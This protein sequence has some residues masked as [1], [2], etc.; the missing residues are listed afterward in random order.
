MITPLMHVFVIFAT[1]PTILFG[2]ITL[3][4][5]ECVSPLFASSYVSTLRKLLSFGFRLFLANTTSWKIHCAFSGGKI[6]VGDKL[7]HDPMCLGM[8]F[9]NVAKPGGSDGDWDDKNVMLL[10]FNFC[11]LPEFPLLLV[12]VTVSACCYRWCIT[13]WKII[14]CTS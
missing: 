14:Y 5:T 12:V 7:W 10:D 6:Q 9:S 8:I 3:K 13:W 4:R 1:E 2:P 11:L